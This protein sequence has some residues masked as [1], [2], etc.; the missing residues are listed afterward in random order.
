MPT[1]VLAIPIIESTA[2]SLYPYFGLQIFTPMIAPKIMI[3]STNCDTVLA[4][5]MLPGRASPKQLAIPQFVYP[6][7]R[8]TDP[9][10]KIVDSVIKARYAIVSRAGPMND[11]EL[12]Q[13]P[14]KV[15]DSQI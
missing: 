11:R 7:E 5:C 15:L 10:A 6:R 4:P 12:P 3:L 1:I 2:T 13:K 9:I 14:P 8:P